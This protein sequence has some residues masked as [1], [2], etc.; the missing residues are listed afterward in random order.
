M[1]KRKRKYPSKEKTTTSEGYKE[2]KK[3]QMRDWRKQQ[4]QLMEQM[5]RNVQQLQIR[6][7]KVYNNIFRNSGSLIGTP[8][9]KKRGRKRN[10]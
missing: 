5:K 7:P 3:L 1:P 9:K 2:Y 8:N 6:Y 4:K 10:K